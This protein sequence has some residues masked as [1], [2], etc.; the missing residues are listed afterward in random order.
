MTAK[1]YILNNRDSILYHWENYDFGYPNFGLIEEIL[2]LYDKLYLIRANEEKTYEILKFS[3][4]YEHR[5][6]N[7]LEDH[8]F[9]RNPDYP[10]NEADLKL[11]EGEIPKEAVQIIKDTLV[12]AF[13][14]D[15]SFG[16]AF[17]WLACQYNDDNSVPYP[18]CVPKKDRI[19][20]CIKFCFDELV[21]EIS[22]L[23]TNEKIVKLIEAMD[24]CY[25]E[26]Y[27]P[28]AEELKLDFINKCNFKIKT[29]EQIAKIHEIPQI[30]NDSQLKYG[31]TRQ[32]LID[33]FGPEQTKKIDNLLQYGYTVDKIVV[34]KINSSDLCKMI[35]SL[36]IQEVFPSQHKNVCEFIISNFKQK[37]GNDYT[38][39]TIMNAKTRDNWS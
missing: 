16:Y 31:R 38:K 14:K 24:D 32:M 12:K 15:N 21:D 22:K 20:F 2:S 3:F 33:N 26:N 9:G 39:K 34:K 29:L 1:S 30:S 11:R 6:R 35:N 37:N 13:E 7:Y 17:Y 23:P 4:G 25:L 27:G 28:D 10:I 8:E 19:E 5:S 36:Y 18:H